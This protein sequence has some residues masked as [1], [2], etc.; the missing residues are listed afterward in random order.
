[1]PLA[2]LLAELTWQG[3]LTVSDL[4]DLTPVHPC[5]TCTLD[6]RTVALAHAA[7]LSKLRGHHADLCYLGAGGIESGRAWDPAHAWMA[8]LARCDCRP[9]H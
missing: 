1:M 4:R 8:G 3:H 6:R 2:M 9:F 7:S 5:G